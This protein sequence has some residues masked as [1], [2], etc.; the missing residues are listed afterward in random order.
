M[1][2]RESS[3]TRTRLVDEAWKASAPFMD[4]VALMVGWI[5]TFA[6]PD[7]LRAF[8]NGVRPYV[9]AIV[10]VGIYE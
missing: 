6:S 4:R 7:E 9:E 10:E 8:P 5:H 3:E 1:L 2:S